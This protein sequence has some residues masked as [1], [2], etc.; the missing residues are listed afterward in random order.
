MTPK[1]GNLHLVKGNLAPNWIFEIVQVD[2][3]NQWWWQPIL[4][5]AGYYTPAGPCDQ[6]S[7]EQFECVYEKP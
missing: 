6:H 5:M 1:I 2:S 3:L 7:L 4:P